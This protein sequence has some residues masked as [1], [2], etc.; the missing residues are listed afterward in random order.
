ML[1]IDNTSTNPY[2]NIALEEY[3]L[4]ETTEDIFMLYVDEPSI[5]IGKHQNTLA[6]INLKYVLENNIAV[7]R[8]I[9]GGGT[10]YH[11][12]GNLNFTF[13][14]NG[15]AGYLVDFKKFTQPIIEVLQKLGLDVRLEGKNDLRVNNLKI[16]GN[17][18]HVF[19]NRVLHHGTILV[20]ANLE[21]LSAALKVESGKYTDNAV[22]SIRS[23]VT[24]INTFLPKPVSVETLK[25]LV[26]EYIQK[27]YDSKSYSI[28]D[29]DVQEVN[30]RVAEKFQTWQWNYGYSPRYEF[31]NSANIDGKNAEIFLEV[32]NGIIRNAKITGNTY[33]Q[34][35]I[36]GC[37]HEFNSIVA[38]L[39]KL[40]STKINSNELIWHFF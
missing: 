3:L 37:N 19:T 1:I 31:R 2:F 30:K 16:S 33:L 18:E 38:L 25:S 7:V 26:F 11:D 10:V 28:S 23:K 14:A 34:E 36:I 39:N 9:S 4:K 40:K 27:Q 12:L 5:I 35:S 8:R 6:E 15:K 13:I 22:K 17:A 21:N 24:N 20:S 29:S 32:E